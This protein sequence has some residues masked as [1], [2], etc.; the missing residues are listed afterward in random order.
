MLV[1][2]VSEWESYR[3]FRTQMVIFCRMWIKCNNEDQRENEVQ[4]TS[5]CA[6]HL[7]KALQKATYYDAVMLIG[8]VNS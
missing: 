3:T 8:P 7:I 4:N 5:H 1:F 2:K 6:L